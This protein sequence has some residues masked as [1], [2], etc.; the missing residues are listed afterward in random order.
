[1]R[2]PIPNTKPYRLRLLACLLLFGFIVL[3]PSYAKQ[4]TSTRVGSI[5]RPDVAEMMDGDQE[6]DLTKVVILREGEDKPELVVLE[7]V[8]Q[9]KGFVSSQD[10][11]ERNSEVIINHMRNDRLRD[12]L[13]ELE[14]NED[15]VVAQPSYIYRTQDWLRTGDKDTPSDFGLSPSAQSGDHWYYEKSN[16]RSA[17]NDQ[18]C[19]EGGASCGGSS[20]VTVAVIDTGLAFED[21]TSD[22]I[23]EGSAP[24]VFTPA[25]DLFSE[26]GINLYTNSD[27]IPDNGVDDDDNG[28]I[29]DYHGVDTENFIYCAYYTCSSTQS[30]ETGHP[31]DD[32]GHGT[33]VTG[34]IA[35][36]VDNSSG[37]V[38]PAHNVTIMPIK[39]NFQKQSSFGTLQLTWAIDYA[40]ENGADIINMSLSGPG[41][42]I[43]LETSIADAAEAGVL[44]VA[45]SGNAGGEVHYPAR[46]ESVIAVGAVTANGSR[47]NYSA[48]GPE[49]DLV[50]YVGEGNGKGDAVYQ[51]SY[52]C[53]G[54]SGDAGCYESSDPNVNFDLDS[55]RYTK[56]ET[57]Y[58]IGTSF[59]APQVAAAAALILGNNQNASID[60][61]KL[62][63][64]SSTNDLGSTG[65]DNETGF[66]VIDYY[67]ANEFEYSYTMGN[68]YQ[69]GGKAGSAVSSVEFAGRLFQSI[70]GNSTNNIYIRSTGDGVF[71]DSEIG[72]SWV[73]VNGHTPLQISLS[74]FNPGDGEKLYM[75]V[76]G[77]SG[78]I[79]TRHTADGTNWTDWHTFS[80]ATS[81]APASIS[82]NDRIYQ[83]V[84][85]KTTTGI[86]IR[87]SLDGLFDG[88]I[89]GTDE[90][91][92]ETWRLLN[93]Q[94]SH[95]VELEV[96]DNKLFMLAIGKSG[97][98]NTMDSVDGEEWSEWRKD[99][100]KTIVVPAMSGFDGRLFQSIKGFSDNNLYL[101]YSMDGTNW[102]SWISYP[103]I[104]PVRTNIG[105]FS[106][107]D[108][109]YETVIGKSGNIFIRSL[110]KVP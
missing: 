1:M 75:T 22:W 109:L 101:R 2:I 42:D 100:E 28:F 89:N 84:R 45:S 52:E 51:M 24:F 40:V 35:S 74:T 50:A 9:A 18:D 14:R 63:L 7:E 82:F 71:D 90:D 49:L 76:I 69:N 54:R 60:E 68:F 44:V 80:G 21:H 93:G 55:L 56:F 96:F 86:Y 47:A 106:V 10:L 70:K 3:K 64:L 107:T 103:G 73:Q 17:W 25:P 59:A 61:I 20:G 92:L 39:A 62:G 72:E 30:A 26:E 57:K 13:I 12:K 79:Y 98:I 83:V 110:Q 99:A 16:L 77:K 81:S 105:Y 102:S 8:E 19:S 94:T 43:F 29:D 48:Y 53:F 37:S 27:E 33:Y 34:L 97:N 11:D 4:D 108:S 95:S 91:F 32:G 66:G 67:K 15:V 23:D 87:S 36:L 65:F 85:G 6:Y 104:S 5:N 58:G 46:Y 41:S 78:G 88:L 38:S 31:N